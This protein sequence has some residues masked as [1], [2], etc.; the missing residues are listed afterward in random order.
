M[1]VVDLTKQNVE[2]SIDVLRFVFDHQTQFHELNITA[3][4]LKEANLNSAPLL[5]KNPIA[6]LVFSVSR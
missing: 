3:L 4:I 1:C 2:Y 5:V 6:T